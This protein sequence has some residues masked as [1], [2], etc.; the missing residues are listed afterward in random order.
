[1][2]TFKRI[3]ILFLTC[4]MFSHLSTG[5]DWYYL[6]VM[7]TTFDPLNPCDCM[8]YS[9]V[10]DE[11][12]CIGNEFVGKICR[13]QSLH[14]ILG[15]LNDAL[16]Q[17][18]SVASHVEELK[19]TL[20]S[21]EYAHTIVF[22]QKYI[23]PNLH[24]QKIVVT[25]L[26][27]KDPFS[28]P[29]KG[30]GETFG[31]MSFIDWVPRTEIREPKYWRC[32][33]SEESII[34]IRNSSDV[35]IEGMDF[36]ENQQSPLLIIDSNV[37]VHNPIIRNTIQYYNITKVAV[38]VKEQVYAFGLGITIMMTDD[39]P[40]TNKVVIENATI[41]D[42]QCVKANET[43]DRCVH[44][45]D[46][47]SIKPS[48]FGGAVG[49]AF[50]STSGV[51]Y[52]NNSRFINN[53]ACDSG[54]GVFIH[55]C[56]RINDGNVTIHNTTIKNNTAGYLGGGVYLMQEI[57][58]HKFF[59]AISNTLI[60]YNQGC[61]AG[62]GIAVLVADRS[63]NFNLIDNSSQLITERISF[64]YVLETK[65]LHNYSGRIS[66]GHA[67]YLKAYD[68][69]AKKQHPVI[70]FAKCDISY[71]QQLN[72]TPNGL[73]FGSILAENF[74]IAF[75]ETN[76]ITNSEAGGILL[77]QSIVIMIGKVNFNNLSA[78]SGGAIHARKWSKI[79]LTNNSDITFN[80]N[81]ASIAGG[82]IFHYFGNWDGYSAS[83]IYNSYCLLGYFPSIRTP[84]REWTSKL[85]FISNNAGA[86]GGAVFVTDLTQCALY[87]GTVQL[88]KAFN[89]TDNFVY[90]NNTVA[91][92]KLSYLGRY[93]STIA[94]S[95]AKLRKLN[96]S[97]THDKGPGIE[98]PINYEPLDQLDQVTFAV[99]RFESPTKG[100]MLSGD[101][102]VI[103]PKIIDRYL[104]C[105][106]KQSSNC[107]LPFFK[108][109]V[110][111]GYIPA[112]VDFKYKIKSGIES[113]NTES[114]FHQE[115]LLTITNPYCDVGYRLSP[116]GICTCNYDKGANGVVKCTSTGDVY[117][118]SGYWGIKK[119]SINSDFSLS[120]IIVKCAHS[121]C[122]CD[123]NNSQHGSSC[124]IPKDPNNLCIAEQNREGDLCGKCKANYTFLPFSVE[125]VPAPDHN[126]HVLMVT[127][128]IITFICA[129][130]IL[131]FRCKFWNG[132][133]ILPL[134]LY[135]LT[136]INYNFD[137]IQH[138]GILR[139]IQ[140]LQGFT[141]LNFYL[142]SPAYKDTT[143]IENEMLALYPVFT[144]LFVLMIF[145]ILSA[146]SYK[147][148]ASSFHHKFK[149]RRLL[150]P[151]I[152][153]WYIMSISLYRVFLD[154]AYCI[155]IMNNATEVGHLEFRNRYSGVTECYSVENGY[156][157]FMT[158]T[159]FLTLLLVFPIPI[160][161][162]I[163]SLKWS[164]NKS[165]T[166]NK[167]V[168]PFKPAGRFQWGWEYIRFLL[169]ATGLVAHDSQPQIGN[170]ILSMFIALL[171]IVHI[172][173]WPYKE[174]SANVIE[175]IGWILMSLIFIID[176]AVTF[177]YSLVD[178]L[179]MVL[180]ILILMLIVCA[181]IVYVILKIFS[182]MAK[183]KF[184][185]I[186]IR[187]IPKRGMSAKIYKQLSEKE[188]EG[189]EEMKGFEKP[190]MKVSDSV[191]RRDSILTKLSL[192]VNTNIN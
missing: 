42:N 153:L 92:G 21:G 74:I 93:Y 161:L 98:I 81:S 137:I 80:N 61:V 94:G 77:I 5:N 158:G 169:L 76:N 40:T 14:Q 9:R 173:V 33:N 126:H 84:P 179:Q 183:D 90:I 152:Y 102:H 171:M 184:R 129:C 132:F 112:S 97:D 114:I 10:P 180:I 110:S 31:V 29:S 103:T 111:D 69:P 147:F 187:V 88:D 188:N 174:R 25:H 134:L 141:I 68:S 123:K 36:N 143:F 145:A 156:V 138:I 160:L 108:Y 105:R 53:T 148:P 62:G 38:G 118:E 177:N 71:N 113:T 28:C 32:N 15:V 65:I 87:D 157:Y 176:N 22:D 45:V 26:D 164:I 96:A 192:A 8:V 104:Q 82:A 91:Q 63:H 13:G 59:M 55:V 30:N 106:A 107:L 146:I 155:P 115:N 154:F 39:T 190:K 6:H 172:S 78:Y 66:S 101:Y 72:N 140:I 186:F 168:L 57:E 41:I 139:A 175:C 124:I 35:F 127:Y 54:G 64:S 117:L 47:N 100:I 167:L 165:Y 11:F 48:F 109:N 86:G 182:I 170:S 162:I 67:A 50:T 17:S 135:S 116:L 44:Q 19:I 70:V 151:A 130:L 49:V 189:K 2:D 119:Q 136:Y 128:V 34:T 1:M 131:A 122:A 46:K 18:S 4:L 144:I 16:N 142:I 120:G 178:G 75:A 83:S 3:Q 73:T 95:V 166:L 99:V 133:R 89:Y 58:A 56:D 181:F 43:N 27:Y 185:S 60:E 37:E 52:I 163:G 24:F 150:S 125:C 191:H 12:D 121:T 23:P 20:D 149:I 7:I 159:T 85:T 51:V 79:L